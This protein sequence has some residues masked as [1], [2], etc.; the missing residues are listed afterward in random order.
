[1]P[2]AVIYTQPF[3]A[4]FGAELACLHIHALCILECHSIRHS[5]MCATAHAN[6]GMHIDLQISAQAHRLPCAPG[7][8]HIS[9]PVPAMCHTRIMPSPPQDRSSIGP[10]LSLPP[11]PSCSLPLLSE[12]FTD[13]AAGAATAGA[14]WLVPV[15]LRL[16]LRWLRPLHAL[17]LGLSEASFWEGCGR[18]HIKRSTLV[19]YRSALHQQG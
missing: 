12:P 17:K 7:S 18:S 13:A 8:V 19:S 15:L 1:M 14:A 16:M 11:P 10:R 9:L 2:C 3:F 5:H 6:D 4:N